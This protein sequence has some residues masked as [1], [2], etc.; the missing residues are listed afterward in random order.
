M[1][2]SLKQQF[3]VILKEIMKLM[4]RIERFLYC[5]I[6]TKAA[7]ADLMQFI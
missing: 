5:T 2:Q 3:P 7:H 6:N 4:S 1:K